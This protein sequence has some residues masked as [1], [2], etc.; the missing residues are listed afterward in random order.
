MQNVTVGDEVYSPSRQLYARVE[1]LFPAA[2]CVRIGVMSNHH[3][4][5]ELVASPQLWSAEDIVN[6]SICHVCGSRELLQREER[7]SIPFHICAECAG[8]QPVDDEIPEIRRQRPEENHRP[9]EG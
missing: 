7:S 5:I 9:T 1:A 3:H 2:V 6:L 4:H 8:M